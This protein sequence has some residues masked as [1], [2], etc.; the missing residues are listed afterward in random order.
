MCNK[1]SN[2][3]CL[4]FFGPI[5]ITQQR[6]M[7]IIFPAQRFMLASRRILG[8]A[9]QSLLGITVINRLCEKI[10]RNVRTLSR[11]LGRPKR[12]FVFFGRAVPASLAGMVS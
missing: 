2:H 7:N 4:V 6:Q 12:F 1:H 9:A 3:L 8:P 5:E 11:G 10:F